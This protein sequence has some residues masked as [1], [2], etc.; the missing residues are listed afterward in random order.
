MASRVEDGVDVFLLDA[1]EA[2]GLIELSL[3]R[4]VLLEPEREISTEFRFVALS[5]ERWTAAFWGCKRNLDAGVL[6]SIV[7]G[8]RAL[9]ARILSFVQSYPIGRGM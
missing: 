9:R 1:V 7:G 2:N 4:C 8:Q 5:I 3:R 6:E